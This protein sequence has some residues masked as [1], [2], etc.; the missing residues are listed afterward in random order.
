M[1]ADRAA[2]VAIA[3]DWTGTAYVMRG[4]LKGAGCDCGTLLAEY[5]IEIG[6]V[7]EIELPYY[8]QD[9]FC[10]ATDQMYYRHL[11]KYAAEVAQGICRGDARPQPGDI[12]L[13]RAV[14]SERFNHGAIVT[15]WPFGVHSVHPHVTESD[16]TKHRLTGFR[17]YVLADPWEKTV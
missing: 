14:G 5:L 11:M 1:I 8:R 2:A 4:R 6:A 7:P 15:S 10:H 16:L 12:M 3:R 13:F 9:W 17:A